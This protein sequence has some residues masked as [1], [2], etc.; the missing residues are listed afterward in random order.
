MNQ[1]YSEWPAIQTLLTDFRTAVSPN[2]SAPEADASAT[3]MRVPPALGSQ[4]PL[5]NTGWPCH[6]S[7]WSLPQELTFCFFCFFFFILLTIIIQKI[8][9]YNPDPSPAAE[10]FFV[11]LFGKASFSVKNYL[12]KSSL[13]ANPWPPP[14]LPPRSSVLMNLSSHWIHFL[15]NG[16]KTKRRSWLITPSPSLKTNRTDSRQFRWSTFTSKIGHGLNQTKFSL[17]YSASQFVQRFMVCMRLFSLPFYTHYFIS[18]PPSSWMIYINTFYLSQCLLL[19]FSFSN[20]EILNNKK[21]KSPLFVL[22]SSDRYTQ[23]NCHAQDRKHFHHPR[24]FL[25]FYFQS[26]SFCPGQL[27][28]DFY[29][30][31]LLVLGSDFIS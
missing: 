13:W 26:I 5:P 9:K 19:T 22:M 10:C 14:L 16:D 3:H 1:L 25:Q 17:L 2:L 15:T 4:Q 31:R 20:W 30:C 24:A 29:H 18:S 27:L 6:R 28:S 11:Y 23:C 7:L 21:H 12:G 8:N